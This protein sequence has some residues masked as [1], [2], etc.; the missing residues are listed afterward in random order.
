MNLKPR[1]SGISMRNFALFIGMF[2]ILQS[3]G[4]AMAA[5]RDGA[6][7]AVLTTQAGKCE[8]AFQLRF[9]ARGS[10]LVT[11]TGSKQSA[12]GALEPD[13]T[14]WLRLKSG[15]DLYRL[16]G[17]MRGASASGTWSSNTRLCGGTWRGSRGN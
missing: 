1:N 17:R 7:T 4:Y 14:L 5:G 10:D 12:D 9:A 3:G 2:A 6:W 8:R 15:R 13:G 11:A 16:Q